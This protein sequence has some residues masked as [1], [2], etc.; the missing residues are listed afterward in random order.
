MNVSDHGGISELESI[1]EGFMAFD[2]EWLITSFNAAAEQ[3]SGTNRADVLGRTYWDAFPLVVGTRIEREFRQ[4]M[5]DRVSRRFENHYAPDGRWFEMVA[6]PVK[7]GGIAVYGRNI[8]GRKNVEEA[9]RRSEAR[10]RSYFELGLIGMAITSPTK[11]VLEVNDEICRILGYERA[12]LL[13]KSWA[14]MTYPDDLAADI[15]L[16][17]RVVSGEIDGYEIDKRWIRK[18]GRIIDSHISVKCV[19]RADNSVEYFVSLLQDITERKLAEKALR[20]SEE[21]YRTLFNSMD[22]GFIVL[23]MIFDHEGKP[24]DLIALEVNPVFKHL[25]GIPD[26]VGKHIREILPDLEESWYRILGNVVLRGEPV[27]AEYHVGPSKR[28]FDLNAFRIGGKESRKVAVLLINITGRKEMEVALR[29]SEE[30]FRAVADLVPDLLW[31]RD[32]QGSVEWYNRRWTE[33]TGQRSE[34]AARFGWLDVIHPDDQD[35]SLAAFY[36][37]LDSGQ[38]MR[39]EHRIRG[40]D[41]SYRWFLHQARPLRDGEGQ[42]VHWFGTATDIHE[43]RM[44]QDILEERVRRRTHD[45]V[46]TNRS[47]ETEIIEHKRADEALLELNEMFQ[48]LIQAAPLAI[49]SLDPQSLVRIWNP[50]AERM[51][52]WSQEEVLGKLLPTLPADI[53]EAREQIAASLR[54][55][56]L[57]GYDSRRRRKDNSQVEVSVWNAP[58]RNTH[59]EVIASVGILADNTERKRTQ[60][61][62]QDINLRLRELSGRLLDVQEEERRTIARELHDEIGQQ[63]TALRFMLEGLDPAGI[64]NYELRI[65]GFGQLVIRNS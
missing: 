30:R 11:G 57:E 50:A 37:A 8:T 16:F 32:A 43:Q 56:Q 59:G 35:Q 47:L 20:E 33:Y 58:V 23:E 40:K 13:Q 27:R 7:D 29:K 22:E 2:S 31:S 24:A 21:R 54:G 62:L 5:S 36:G 38:P 60:E 45:L 26:I 18:D 41:G 10:F 53:P 55:E 63:L 25:T 64:T 9:L 15:A 42:I 12:E 52:G 65:T 49:Y 61:E 1:A 4:V 48:A 39:H 44:I 28:W 14:E 17:N 19:R 6:A 34:E 51:F 3:E 46:S